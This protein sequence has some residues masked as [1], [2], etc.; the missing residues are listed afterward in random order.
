MSELTLLFS[1][2]LVTGKLE[3]SNNQYD[4]IESVFDKTSFKKINLND[5]KSASS[6]VN[7]KVLN[8]TNLQFLKKIILN[9]FL[10]FNN[11]ILKYDVKFKITTS[12]FTNSTQ[13]EYAQHHNHTNSMYSGVFYFTENCSAIQFTNFNKNTSFGLKPTEYN[14]YNSSSWQINPLK[15][16]ILLFPSEVHHCINISKNI[17]KSLAFN[18]VPFGKY[19]INDSFVDIRYV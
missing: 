9:F 16:T 6:S 1:K 15:G 4:L 14:I 5:E 17:R 7:L 12:W 2:L 3:L 8:D 19:G 13:G 18:I 11:E 10:R